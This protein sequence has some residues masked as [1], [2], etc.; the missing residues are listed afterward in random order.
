MTSAISISST[1]MNLDQ[2]SDASNTVHVYDFQV[3]LYEALF[4]K[5]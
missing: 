4:R 2:K 1:S 3:P 5:F